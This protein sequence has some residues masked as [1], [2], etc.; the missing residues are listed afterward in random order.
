MV[1]DVKEE[2]DHDDDS[3][4]DEEDGDKEDGV[5]GIFILHPLSISFKFLCMHQCSHI[6]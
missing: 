6:P 2:E 4:E 3:D 1:E 5:L